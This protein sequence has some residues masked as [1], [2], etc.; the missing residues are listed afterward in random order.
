MLART[1]WDKRGLARRMA[2][3]ILAAFAAFV[4]VAGPANAQRRNKDKQKTEGRVLS[5]Q[6]G[7]LVLKVQEALQKD[8]PDNATALKLINQILA[9]KKLTPYEKAIAYQFKG[10]VSYALNNI[11]D[12]IKSWEAAIATGALNEDE[13]NSLTPNIGQLYIASGKY[14]KGATMLENW[15]KNGGKGNDRIHLMIA[16]AWLQADKYRK[17]LP[18]AEAAF[19]MAKPKKKKHFD[20]L[21][22]IYH[23]LKMYGKQ[24]DLLEQEVTIWPDDKK[25]WRGIASL[26]QQA[27]KSRE[28]FEINKLMYL[29][30][31]LTKPRELVALAQYYSYYEV[32]Y[33]GA[34]ILEREMNAGRVPKTKKNLVLLAN[35]WR[36]AREYDRAIPVLTAAAKI[37][38]DG[39][40][41]E[42]LGEAYYAEEQYDKAEKAFRKALQK[43]VKKPGNVHVLIANSL[44]ERKKP[45]EAIKEF[46]KAVKYPYSRKTAK[47]WIKFINGEFEVARR[48]REFRAKVKLDECKNQLD[49]KKRMGAEF[50]EG[51]GEIT[52][53]CKT[54]LAKE[55]ARKK[56]LKKARKKAKAS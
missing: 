50:L 46:Q 39:S 35:M 43:G 28:A 38:P 25:I 5:T 1:F 23:E 4:F 13:I 3:A 21:N 37:A 29:N 32:P 16:Q 2:V 56:A 51:V 19:R 10:Q 55:E 6:V 52:P 45:H 8:P 11:P 7:E 17:A 26:K 49:R 9:K 27:N 30:G 48:Q 18:H 12:T 14:V 31:M 47:G 15:L 44:Y 36:Q 40:L 24:A 34:S 41:Y 33:R 54:I 22:Y 53:E 20:I 42:K